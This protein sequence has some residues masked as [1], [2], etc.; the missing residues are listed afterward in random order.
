MQ[1]QRDL[2]GP[3]SHAPPSQ[4]LDDWLTP[5]VESG[6]TLSLLS[7]TGHRAYSLRESSVSSEIEYALRDKTGMPLG[8]KFRYEVKGVFGCG[9]YGR[10]VAFKV[11]HGS[12]QRL[13]IAF[14]GVRFAETESDVN[15]H[16]QE[17]DVEALCQGEMVGL[18]WLPHSKNRVSLGLARYHGSLFMECSSTSMCGRKCARQAYGPSLGKWLNAQLSDNAPVQIDRCM[19]VRGQERAV[20]R[21]PLAAPGILPMPLAPLAHCRSAPPAHCPECCFAYAAVS[22]SWESRSV[23]L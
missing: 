8:P 7:L 13:V 21:S 23:V 18:V 12:E 4:S 5:L 14:R 10:A 19:L 20:H 9:S 1:G 17:E 6:E 2:T 16:A 15:Y 11:L 3:P 22:S